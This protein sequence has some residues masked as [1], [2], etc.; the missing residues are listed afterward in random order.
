M[1]TQIFSLERINT[2]TG[3]MLIV[4][5]DNHCMRAADWEDHEQRMRTLLRQQYGTS[6]I[7]LRETAH[8]SA[9]SRSLDA[10][11]AGDLNAIDS[12]P[13]ATK[14]TEFQRKVWE[15]LRRIPVGHTI[16]YSALAAQIGRPTATRAV[17]HANGSNPI[18]IV[19]PCHRVIGAN[20]SLTG[21]GG[22]LDRKRWL[23][24][25]E[26]ACSLQHGES[27]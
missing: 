7:E 19:V 11:F 26:S 14:G 22:G 24:A 23:L 18:S 25:H 6:A 27:N 13:V 15:A 9:A 4:T 3:R 12:L 21:Y 17:G 1:L 8:P 16:S 10:Y 2:P 5:D 20:A